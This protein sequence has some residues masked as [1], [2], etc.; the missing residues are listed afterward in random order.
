M[1]TKKDSAVG[2]FAPA[3][4]V[5]TSRYLLRVLHGAKSANSFLRASH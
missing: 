2:G 5:L 4:Q 3:L 1:F